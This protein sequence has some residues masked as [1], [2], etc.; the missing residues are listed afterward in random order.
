M[1]IVNMPMIN[2]GNGM[3]NLVPYS[4]R[5]NSK[6]AV[7]QFRLRS[8]EKNRHNKTEDCLHYI[9]DFVRSLTP[10]KHL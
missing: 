1:S 7:S 8:L 2:K 3:P 4:Y 5:L 6:P 10:I 9:L